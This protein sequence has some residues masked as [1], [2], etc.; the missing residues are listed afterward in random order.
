[1]LENVAVKLCEVKFL[2]FQKMLST[3]ESHLDRCHVVILSYCH[4]SPLASLKRMASQLCWQKRHPKEVQNDVFRK[5]LIGFEKF[6][7]GFGL[8]QALQS[9]EK[10]SCLTCITLRHLKNVCHTNLQAPHNVK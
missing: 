7:P 2:L 9:T 5:A 8:S 1:M 6:F 10:E 4:C 3:F